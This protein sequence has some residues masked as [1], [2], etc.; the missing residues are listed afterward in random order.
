MADNNPNPQKRKYNNKDRHSEFY[1]LPQR[2][3][4]HLQE[5]MAPLRE[6]CKRLNIPITLMM[7]HANTPT[8]F[9]V[10][11]FNMCEGNRTSDPIY[12]LCTAVEWM[13]SDDPQKKE[14]Y[15]KLMAF[16]KATRICS[17]A[18]GIGGPLSELLLS[19][20]MAGH[21]KKSDDQ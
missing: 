20:M 1:Q 10:L 13:Q 17:D 18:G 19:M 4:E 7:Q 11:G 9:G 14:N 16:I 3:I 21:D 12:A 8:G 15:A 5:L 6:E 2:D